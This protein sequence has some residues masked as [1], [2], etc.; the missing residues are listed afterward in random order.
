MK[1]SK[2]IFMN[3]VDT[4][5]DKIFT[6]L[7]WRITCP[8]KLS[9]ISW[10]FLLSV[11]AHVTWSRVQWIIVAIQNELKSVVS[12]SEAV[13]ASETTSMAQPV[14]SKL[15]IIAY[16]CQTEP[17]TWLDSPVKL[18]SIRIKLLQTTS[19]LWC[20]KIIFLIQL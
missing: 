20:H 16:K 17:F 19:W 5:Y 1:T 12:L 11:V 15:A 2:R 14:R 4:I 9:Q 6:I 18:L 7:L 3:Y 8:L 10:M 13:T